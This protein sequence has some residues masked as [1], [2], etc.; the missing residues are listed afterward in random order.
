MRKVIPC[1][2][3]YLLKPSTE[4]QIPVPGEPIDRILVSRHEARDGHSKHVPGEWG[5]EQQQNTDQQ[6][7]PQI[8]H[9]EFLPQRIVRVSFGRDPV[10]LSEIR[11]VSFC[12]T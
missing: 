10:C 6:K 5:N 7:I 9:E 12:E 1:I 3:R 2:T 4:T 11:L 8:R